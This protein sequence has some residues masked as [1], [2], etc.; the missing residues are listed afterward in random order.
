[1]NYPNRDLLV[2]FNQEI[3]SPQAIRHEVDLLHQL[4]YSVEGID[5]LVITHEI[6][7]LNKYK[8]I[9]KP[10]LLRRVFRSGHLKPFVF[11]NCKN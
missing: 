8:R 9:D 5:G 1:M 11:L 7:D 3:M 6:L 10:H 2:L 4:L